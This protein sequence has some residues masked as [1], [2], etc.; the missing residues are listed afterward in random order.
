MHFSGSAEVESSSKIFARLEKGLLL[1][2]RV[3]LIISHNSIQFQVEPAI[4]DGSGLFNPEKYSKAEKEEH[5]L[6]A[7]EYHHDLAASLVPF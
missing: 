2:C 1:L 5:L 4:C 3:L 7:V 6:F